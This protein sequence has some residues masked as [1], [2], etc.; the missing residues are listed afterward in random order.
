[1]KGLNLIS[2]IFGW[3]EWAIRMVLI[4]WWRLETNSVL[5]MI[6]LILMGFGGLAMIA[7]NGSTWSDPFKRL[8][9]INVILTI[10]FESIISAVCVYFKIKYDKKHDET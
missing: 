9:K 4:L 8:K 7:I 1:M 2:I 3:I 6:L 5:A 10:I